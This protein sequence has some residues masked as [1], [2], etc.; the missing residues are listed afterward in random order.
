MARS[1]STLGSLCFG[2]FLV[3]NPAYF[4]SC[5]DGGGFQ[6]GEADML[7]VVEQL[8]ETE[9][10]D[11]ATPSE[12]SG[13]QIDFQLEQASAVS[14]EETAQR[15]PTQASWITSA[16]ACDD[17]T[18]VKAAAACSSSSSLLLAGTARIKDGEETVRTLEVQGA[19]EVH[20]NLL[21][22]A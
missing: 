10:L 5:S 14:P 1:A 21:T 6:Y 22:Q 12:L 7:E 3:A 17:R 8:N 13:Y 2:F 20:S 9:H 15:A 11:I 16:H 19:M 4:V 18:F